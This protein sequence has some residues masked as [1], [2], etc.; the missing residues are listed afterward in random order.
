MIELIIK[1]Q[2]NVEQIA[3]AENGKLVEWYENDEDTK[4]NRLEGNIYYSRV[5]DILPGMQAAFVDFGENKKGFIHLKDVVPQIDEKKEK[6]DSSLTIK[7][8]LKLNDNLLI[9]VKKDAA[10]TKGARVST[11]I[12]LP[13]KYIVY[14]PDTTIVTISQ[15]IENENRK[16]ELLKFISENLP[17]G[18]GAI[19]RTSA[20]EASNEE[21]LNDVKQVV[22][23][24][25][26]IKKQVASCKKSPKLIAQSEEVQEKIITDLAYKGLEKVIVN[27][28]KEYN[29]MKKF[30][31]MQKFDI[32]IELQKKLNIL[33]KYDIEKQI[34]KMQNRK[35]WLNCGGFITIDKTE[36]LTAIDVNTG[37]FTGT[38]DVEKTIFKVNKEATIQIAK[39]LRLR[40][41]GGIII[42]DYIDMKNKENKVAIQELLKNSLKYD[43][44][45]TQIEGFTNLNLMELT[46]KCIFGTKEQEQC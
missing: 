19:I 11:H 22:K 10:K 35:I 5:T 21:I 32:K 44:A 31:E 33:E 14:M 17:K 20:I 12:S 27:D 36:A 29:K 37:K 23:K 2:N 42:I 18:N 43:R 39:E 3:L 40:D 41:I 25:E 34:E 24:W 6:F 28:E 26:D 13:S 16:Q 1:K 46:R 15:K 4:K 9:Q 45:K 7:D 30:I 38:K 8:V